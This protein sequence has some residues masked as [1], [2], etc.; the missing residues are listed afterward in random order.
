MAT[1]EFKDLSFFDNKDSV[2][3]IFLDGYYFEIPKE[4]LSAISEY[5]ISKKSITFE[6]LNEK[7]ANNKFSMILSRGFN[8]LKSIRNNK[9]AVYIHQNSGIPLIGNTMFGIVDKGTNIIEL[10]PNTDCNMSCIFC[11]VDEGVGSKKTGEFVVE[12]DYLVQELKILIEFKKKDHLTIYINVHGEPLLYSPLKELIADIK[13]FKEV[14]VITL[15]TNGA[16]LTNKVID[17]LVEAGLNQMSCSVSGFDDELSKR[18]MGNTAYDPKKVRE[19]LTYAAKKLKLI[20]TPVWLNGINDSQMP[21]IIDFAKEIGALLGI[22]NFMHNQKGRNP[23]KEIAL[24]E[25]FS[26]LK[27][28]EAEHKVVL[29]SGPNEFFATK[30]YE[31]PFNKDQTIKAEIMCRGRFKN[32]VIAAARGR[33]IVVSRCT[34][35][36]GR[37]TIK[38]TKDAHNIFA[39]IAV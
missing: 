22:Q 23:V 3:V 8:E 35:D 6:G 31:K 11:S 12:K 20:I 27:K 33:N 17:E 16:L 15:I 28:L 34:K 32:E 4:D 18:L 25:F 19:A 24:E 10:K 5:K 1:L 39:G 21:K 9:Q 13:N 38:L 29:I 7:S 37:I 2:K 14:D 36:R 26:K 30:E